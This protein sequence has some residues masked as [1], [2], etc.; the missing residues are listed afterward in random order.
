MYDDFVL[1]VKCPI[2][3]SDGEEENIEDTLILL[4][5]EEQNMQ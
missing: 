3:L 4:G 2:C 1:R 5:D